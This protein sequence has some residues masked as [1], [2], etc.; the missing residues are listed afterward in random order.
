VSPLRGGSEHPRSDGWSGKE[1]ASVFY[2]RDEGDWKKEKVLL[3][4]S[5]SAEVL[6]GV[7]SLGEGPF[8]REEMIELSGSSCVRA[9]RDR[10]L[11]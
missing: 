4:E 6:R 9:E 8:E 1:N 2:E 5:Q 10:V 7:V 3:G 11:G